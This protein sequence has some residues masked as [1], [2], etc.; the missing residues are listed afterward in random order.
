MF[1]LVSFGYYIFLLIKKLNAQPTTEQCFL[2]WIILH[3]EMH[4]IFVKRE[5]KP[6]GMLPI[7]KIFS[8]TNP[9]YGSN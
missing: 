1:L 5:L 4:K 8:K 3:E 6:K 7:Y 2:P 9:A